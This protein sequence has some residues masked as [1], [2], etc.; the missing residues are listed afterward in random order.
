MKKAIDQDTL[1]ALI[2]TGA[3]REFLVTRGP[4]GEGWTLST[5]LATTWLPI[6]S[7]REPIRVWVRIPRSS[8]HPFHE[9]LAT[10][11]TVI[12]PPIPRASGH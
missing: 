12:R 5:R 6:R 4:G 7:R 11:S 2:E 3:A 8:G 1:Q 10:D 9:H